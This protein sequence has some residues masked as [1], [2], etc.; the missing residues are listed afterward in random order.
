[1]VGVMLVYQQ[2]KEKQCSLKVHSCPQ[3]HM[4]GGKPVPGAKREEKSSYSKTM[5]PFFGSSRTS[6][7]H[8]PNKL[9][10]CRYD[11]KGRTTSE[12][13]F[14]Q[15]KSLSPKSTQCGITYTNTNYHNLRLSTSQWS[16]S[17]QNYL[18]CKTEWL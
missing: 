17:T 14:N 8:F 11:N 15:M 9:Q 13:D 6:Q 7:K 10:M 18:V 12:K 3:C 5:F 1:M 16:D 2:T 4:K